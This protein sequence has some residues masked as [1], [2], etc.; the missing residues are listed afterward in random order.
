MILYIYIRTHARTRKRTHTHTHTHTH[1]PLSRF[2]TVFLPSSLCRPIQTHVRNISHPN[3]GATCIC[4]QGFASGPE[5]PFCNLQTASGAAQTTSRN[6]TA[7]AMQNAATMNFV[8]TVF[9][10]ACIG[11]LL[12]CLVCYRILCFRKLKKWREAMVV[13]PQP[14]L[15]VRA[16]D[17]VDDIIAS[18]DDNGWSNLQ[19]PPELEDDDEDEDEPDGVRFKRHL[20]Q[21]PASGQVRAHWRLAYIHTHC[22]HVHAHTCIPPPSLCSF[23]PPSHLPALHRALLPCCSSRTGRRR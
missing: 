15:R 13:F 9:L 19:L 4:F 12:M 3:D 1:N 23:L 17:R 10:P 6:A 7:I 16:Q 22:A 20:R 14:Q 21:G 18:P 11:S 8:L 5:R 2:D